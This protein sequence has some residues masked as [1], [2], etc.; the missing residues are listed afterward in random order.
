MAMSSS[1]CV[2]RGQRLGG[3]VAL[4]ATLLQACSLT[5]T[6]TASEPGRQIDSLIDDVG[7]GGGQIDAPDVWHEDEFDV[8]YDFDTEVYSAAADSTIIADT[9]IEQDVTQKIDTAS[10]W[11]GPAYVASSNCAIVSSAPSKACVSVVCPAKTA[12]MGNGVCS[13]TITFEVSDPNIYSQAPSLLALA[14]GGWIV[15]YTGSSNTSGQSIYIKRYGSEDI[16]GQNALPVV[17]IPT[18]WQVSRSTLGATTSGH[19][20]LGWCEVSGPPA[21]RR[22]RVGRL[23]MLTSSSL[24]STSIN[25]LNTAPLVGSDPCSDGMV[26][27][28]N[29]LRLVQAKDAN[30]VVAVWAGPRPSTTSSWGIWARRVSASDGPLNGETEI[31][32]P[33][34]LIQGFD[35]AAVP[36]GVLVIWAEWIAGTKVSP[37]AIRG[38]IWG[39]DTSTPGPIVTLIPPGKKLELVGYPTLMAF[40]NGDFSVAWKTGPYALK[41]GPTQ[42]WV[43]TFLGSPFGTWIGGNQWLGVDLVGIMPDNLVSTTRYGDRGVIAWAHAYETQPKVDGGIYVQRYFRKEPTLGCSP[44]VPAVVTKFADGSVGH[45]D[46]ISF[47][48]GR[49]LLAWG[50]SGGNKYPTGALQ[51]RFLGD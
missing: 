7:D 12:C 31:K 19:V 51:F 11:I 5:V 39:Q 37:M 10:A 15:A 43:Q 40:P 18:G 36:S 6:S 41:T 42:H 49:V 9:Q 45:A 16:I 4:F 23:P 26:S 22:F 24:V 29:A 47:P 21:K 1:P 44:Q 34:G 46:L 20:M 25:V 3:M 48:D 32:A 2:N 30:E 8:Q 35:A 38:R 13:P 28:G 33:A 14:D 27:N 50:R 17:S